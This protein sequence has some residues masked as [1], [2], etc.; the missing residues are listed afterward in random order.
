MTYLPVHTNGLIDIQQLND[1]IRPDTS[2]VS[3]MMVNNEIGV[4]QPVEDIGKC[5]DDRKGTCLCKHLL[6]FTG[7]S[8]DCWGDGENYFYKWPSTFLLIK[9]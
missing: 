5:F 3:I 1:A 8:T 4:R 2:L 7:K 6:N 9:H